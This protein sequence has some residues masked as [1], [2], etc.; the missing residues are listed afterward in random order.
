MPYVVP[1]L[2]HFCR[3]VSKLFTGPFF[4][5]F[6]SN[7]HKYSSKAKVTSSTA[8]MSPPSANTRSCKSPTPLGSSAANA[9]EPLS[10][11]ENQSKLFSSSVA[12]RSSLQ[13]LAVQS[14]LSNSSGNRTA[15][16]ED[17]RREL[18][19]ILMNPNAHE[20]PELRNEFNQKLF[21]YA[22][23]GPL[24]SDDIMFQIAR[25]CFGM[26]SFKVVVL[27]GAQVGKTS[28]VNKLVN[29]RFITKYKATQG[30]DA[31]VTSLVLLMSGQIV[32]NLIYGILQVWIRL[33][34]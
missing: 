28:Y 4:L 5:F 7:N 19:N 16:L 21:K 27:G 17:K 30:A 15:P 10:T 23:A 1:S 25:E 33:E 3:H 9:K 14:E 22:K 32:S 26:K 13:E 18:L 34:H 11:V 8:N 2:S 29:G 24:A 31:D 6:P 12:I 20:D